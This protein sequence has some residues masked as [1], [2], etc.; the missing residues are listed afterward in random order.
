MA[1]SQF[2][3]PARA[4]LAVGVA[5]LLAFVLAA[6][7]ANSGTSATQTATSSASAASQSAAATGGQVVKL[8]GLKFDPSTLTIPVGTKV[9]FQNMDSLDHTVTN[10]KDGT[11]EANPLFDQSVP[12][13]ASF[14]FTFDKAGTFN[15]TCKIHKFM[16]MTV[17]VQ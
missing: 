5:V 12:L 8:S 2:I 10:G 14:E 3:R 13:G 11:P 1:R 4:A 15:V 17:T 16:K 9:T 6:C 7:S